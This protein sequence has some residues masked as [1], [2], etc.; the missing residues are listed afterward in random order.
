MR[1]LPAPG[2]RVEPLG[3]RRVPVGGRAPIATES[4]V[5]ALE[6][7]A[8]PITVA[9]RRSRLGILTTAHMMT[10]MRAAVL[11]LIYP[12]LMPAMGFGYVQLGL[13]LSITRVV[14][15]LM[16][17]IWGS[18]ARKI[19]AQRLIAG[20]QVGVAM[21]LAVTAASHSYG[22]LTA[23]VTFG[24]V[25]QSPHHPLASAMLS[26][27]FGKERG[28]AL[29]V[30]FSGA[31]LA[32]VI[33]PLIATFLLARWGWRDALYVFA[34]PAL[35]C[36]ALV[37][38]R[39]PVERG[40]AAAAGTPHERRAPLAELLAPLR[41]PLV[42]RLV[43]TASITAGGK[44]MGIVQTFIPLL[45]VEGLH[46]PTAQT[47]LLFTCFTAT[48]VAG[49]YLAGRLSDR[50][51]RARFLSAMLAAS[52]VCA[53]GTV[54]LLHASLWLLM[55]ALVVFGLFIYGLSPVE[56]AILGDLTEES[57]SE[58][59]YS[60]FYAIT[61]ATSAVWPLILTAVLARW[62]FQAA[63]GLIGLTYVVGMFMYGRGDWSVPEA[64]L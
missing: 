57:L 11:P 44:G 50:F 8:A 3:N 6:T 35:A 60:A 55:P 47:G 46:L 45:L 54:A 63:F 59:A 49:P 25:A 26:R 29:A 27:W 13:M 17:G 56:Q 2:G 43:Y 36:S 5:A 9:D 62:G 48:S 7:T 52:A 31:N 20:E 64:R 16:Q 19:P 51:P 41:E 42:R 34:V 22:E 18:V 12:L 32:T 10:H 21:G 40:A 30:H 38:F 15:G 1:E 23:A 33:S 14:G 53:A 37:L 58:Q 24:Q 61:F 39:L 28:H 4:A